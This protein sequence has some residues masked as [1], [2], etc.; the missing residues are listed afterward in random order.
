MMPN[1]RDHGLSQSVGRPSRNTAFVSTVLALIG[2]LVLVGPLTIPM[3]VATLLAGLGIGLLAWVKIK[4]QT[5]DVLG[6]T[7][8]LTEIIVLLSVIALAS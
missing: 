1:A 3:A 7:Q 5:G 8:Q 4:G 6:A 2:C